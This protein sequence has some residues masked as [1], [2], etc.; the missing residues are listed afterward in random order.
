MNR[1]RILDKQSRLVDNQIYNNTPLLIVLVMRDY[2]ISA[3]K[4]KK[5]IK[6]YKQKYQ[7]DKCKNCGEYAVAYFR[8]CPVMYVGN[9]NNW[10]GPPYYKGESIAEEVEGSYDIYIFA[11]ICLSCDKVNDVGIE[12]PTEG[13]MCNNC[14]GAK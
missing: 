11:H 2:E 1:K 9:D 7:F 5:L 10:E 6:R 3:N 14:N 13:N 4:A 8:S 12:E